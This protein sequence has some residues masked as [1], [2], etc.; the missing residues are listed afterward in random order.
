LVRLNARGTQVKRVS[1]VRMVLVLIAVSPFTVSTLN[2]S[3]ADPANR[4]GIA[5][6]PVWRGVVVSPKSRLG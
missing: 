5:S 1:F 3:V 2:F 6:L 4:S